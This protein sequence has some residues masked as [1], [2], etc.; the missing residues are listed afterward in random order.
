MTCC[1]SITI[2][3]GDTHEFVSGQTVAEH[4]RAAK[5]KVKSCVA[6]R[7]DGKLVDASEPVPDGASLEF[8]TIDQEAG[9]E[10]VR[11][12]AAHILAHALS[13]LWP[14]VKLAIGPVI[15]DGFYYDIEMEHRLTPEDLPIIE[16]RMK[17]LAQSNYP[18][19]REVVTAG[20][21]LQEFKDRNQ[22]YKQKIV[23]DIPEGEIIALYRHQEY[24]DMCRGPHVINSGVVQNFK[25]THL[26]GAYWRGDS[27][28]PMLQR[29]Y[30]T[31]WPTKQELALWQKRQ[32]EALRRDH[33]KIG[34]EMQLFHTQEEAPGMVFWHPSGQTIYTRLESYIR[35]QT[36]AFG[37]QEIKTP[38]MLD[39]S[40]WEKSGHADKF[41]ENM[42]ITGDD[43]RQFALKPMNCPGHV[44][45]FSHRSRSYRELPV[46]FAEFGCCHRKEPSGTL[47]GIMRV[48]AFVQ[49]DGHIFCSIDQV[50]QE[51]SAFID[52][53]LS[54]YQTL[55]F[56]N[57][58]LALSTR[59]E[60][61]VGDDKLWD[62]A[63]Q[64]LERVL[65]SSGKEFKVL[66]GE[67][68]FYGPKIEF[69]LTDTI[70]REW[71][72]GTAQLDFAV[73]GRLGASYIDSEDNKTVPVMIHRAMLGSMERF[74]GIMVEEY[75][76]YFP[77]WLTPVQVC[78]MSVGEMQVDYAQKVAQSLTDAG[79]STTTDFTNNKLGYKIRHSRNLRVPILVVI[80]ASEQENGTVSVRRR[81]V[82]AGVVA[83]EDLIEE[84][85]DE[86]NNK[87]VI[88]TAVVGGKSEATNSS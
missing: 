82:D 49:D 53:T 44:Q 68:A 18:I 46:R 20:Q 30:G 65:L 43:E 87:R 76:G 17:Q 13:Q 86:V 67:G 34:K 48:R 60:Q 6:G 29:I 55:G 88:A 11:H 72:C 80:G 59:P 5:P 14:D 57:V 56:D 50:E 16:K 21:A 7:I 84:I 38:Q 1:M 75:E 27:S 52:Q 81:S 71:Q 40:L 15:K 62:L 42:Y 78:V 19:V 64:T 83:L 2:L 39:A 31:L 51:I 28:N 73:P 69:T 35:E 70:G 63:E 3:G 32:E 45:I 61:R 74:L 33:R 4:A 8:I 85:Q 22:V 12:S 77:L 9:L 58:A 37:Y 25:L 10:V 26:A 23:E 24:T 79:I 66:E 36:L 47:H 41:A 54:V